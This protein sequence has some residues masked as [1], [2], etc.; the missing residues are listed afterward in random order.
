[1]VAC[2]RASVVR[3][4]PMTIRGTQPAVVENFEHDSAQIVTGA[5][6]VPVQPAGEGQNQEL[7]GEWERFHGR[8]SVPRGRRKCW[9]D[10]TLER[11]HHTGA[12]SNSALR[13]PV[14]GVRGRTA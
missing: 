4:P 1:M 14:F 6:L 12:R 9:R 2:R 10:G 3:S 8:S 11:L 5:L 13:S 7:S